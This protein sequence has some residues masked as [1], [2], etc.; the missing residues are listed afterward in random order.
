MFDRAQTQFKEML[1]VEELGFLKLNDVG[2]GNHQNLALKKT[3]SVGSVMTSSSSYEKVN[4][5]ELASSSM[6][7]VPS[8][9]QENVDED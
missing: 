3:E 1:A 5:Q 9:V 4:E 6:W 2:H 8:T 7:S